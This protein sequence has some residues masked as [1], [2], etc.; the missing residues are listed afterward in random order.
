[1]LDLIDLL[2]A[3]ELITVA[4]IAAEL[5]VSARTVLR[6]LATLRERGWP[7]AAEPGPGGGVLLTRDRGL[8]AANLGL[9]EVASLWL[10]AQLSAE[11][12]ALPWSA[13]ARAAL[14]KIIASLPAPRAKVLRQLLRRVIVGP[15]ATPRVRES[16]GRASSEL[17][18]AFEEAFAR[19][20]CLE[21]DYVDRN[22]ARSHR[23]V[24]PH[25]LLVEPPAW[26]LLV[27][28]LA[29]GEARMFRMDRIRRPK[30][31]EGRS[32]F[33]NFEGLRRQVEAQRACA[34]QR[35]AP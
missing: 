4:E 6:D 27:L 22:G 15:P 35:G 33:P 23:L 17:L 11:A 24:E 31:H 7:I 9:H 34:A 18:V 8:S 13:S 25:G 10:A 30:V 12:S 14:D 29:S 21:F 16:L 32:F 28:D 19:G 20:L 26:Y 5:G 2:R 3:R 1:M